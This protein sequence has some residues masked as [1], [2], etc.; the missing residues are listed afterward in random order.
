MNSYLILKINSSLGEFV[1][2][3]VKF[4]IQNKILVNENSNNKAIAYLFINFIFPVLFDLIKILLKKFN[5][6]QLLGKFEIIQKIATFFNLILDYYFKLRYIF[7]ADS[8]FFSFIDFL[9]KY[10]TINKGSTGSFSEKFLN[11]GKQINIFLLFIMIRIGEWYF[12][13]DSNTDNKQ[14]NIAVPLVEKSVMKSVNNGSLKEIPQKTFSKGKCIFCDKKLNNDEILVLI[15]CGL[16]F[17][18][19]CSKTNMDKIYK[20]KSSESLNCP[21]CT[22]R[23]GETSYIKIYP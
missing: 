8:K 7:F 4:D 20:N 16:I 6:M 18:Q 14:I 5:F 13:K 9:F 23:I 22:K 19:T 2:N 3:F 10:M 12:S 15:C 11:I 21:T 17:C 1:L